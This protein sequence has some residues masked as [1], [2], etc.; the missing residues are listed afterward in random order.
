MEESSFEKFGNV[1][2]VLEEQEIKVLDENISLIV[3][4]LDERVIV[5]IMVNIFFRNIFFMIL[6]SF[7]IRIIDTVDGEIPPMGIQ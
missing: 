4:F 1:F 2:M 5:R 7:C 3:Q 6:C